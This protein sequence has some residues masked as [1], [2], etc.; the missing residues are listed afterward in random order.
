MKRKVAE[1]SVVFYNNDGQVEVAFDKAKKVPKAYDSFV[2][3]IEIA[4]LSAIHK[5]MAK[6]EKGEPNGE[7]TTSQSQKCDDANNHSEQ[8]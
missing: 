4:T 6:I 3:C 8:A 5:V 1:F 7:T 2:A